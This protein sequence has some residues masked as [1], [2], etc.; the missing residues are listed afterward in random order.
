MDLVITSCNDSSKWYA[1][2]VGSVVPL[3]AIEET[4][5][6]TLQPS[7]FVNFISKCDATII[8]YDDYDDETDA[9]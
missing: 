3:L 2:L 9:V 7:G 6:K 8:N 5:Y 1:G 4:E